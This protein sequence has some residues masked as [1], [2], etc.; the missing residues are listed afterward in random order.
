[1][2][3]KRKGRP[4]DGVVLINKPRGLSSN[5]VLQRVKRLFQAAK[6]GHTG[7][8]D[9]LAT[10]LLPICL[11]EATKFS[12]LLLD[13]D[14]TYQALAQLGVRTDS[15][16]ADGEVTE[17]RP[18]PEFSQDQVKAI[19]KQNLTGEL[20]QTAPVYSALKVNG[21]PMYK[22]AREGKVVEP[23]QRQV[24]V[25]QC[26][27]MDCPDCGEHQ[28]RL[29]IRCSKGTY[30]RSLVD[31]L[32]QLLDCGAHVVELHRTGHGPYQID[33]SYTLE[34]LE[35]L[36][37]EGFDALDNTL[38]ATDSSVPDWPVV[39]LE[40]ADDT[41]RFCHGNPVPVRVTLDDSSNE[42]LRIRV[43]GDQPE[44]LLGIGRINSAGELAP[45]RLIVC[46]S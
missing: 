30:I 36:A 38:L 22:L 7:A 32:G 29:N 44:R 46:H 13:S 17:T 14:K 23:K 37:E 1:M 40:S 45:D 8:L 4:I 21:Q 41:T 3:K 16:D 43:Y 28:L 18:V 35:A 11:G 2:A 33:Q 39:H 19:I 25:Y 20:Q 26:E 27:L 10:G 31:E 34:Q 15:F 12:Q 6:A 5:Q 42:S 24:T 9:P